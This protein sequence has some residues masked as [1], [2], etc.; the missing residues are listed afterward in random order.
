MASNE[1]TAIINAVLNDKQFQEGVGKMKAKIKEV[2]K[3]GSSFLDKFNDPS[4]IAKGILGVAAFEALKKVG[5]AIFDM[6]KQAGEFIKKNEAFESVF[7][8]VSK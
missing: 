5:A 6:T 4:L 3:E 1:V 7:R 8:G 2:E